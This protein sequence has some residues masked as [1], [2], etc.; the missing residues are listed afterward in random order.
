VPQA[1][2]PY[3]LPLGRLLEDLALCSDQLAGL[4]HE[5]VAA[6]PLASW[7]ETTIGV[8]YGPRV[9][10]ALALLRRAQAWLDLLDRE[11]G[12]GVWLPGFA[13]GAPP[14]EAQLGPR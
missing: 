8:S 9:R 4:L 3:T 1:G 12:A 14:I 2:A 7:P 10:S 6:L 5:T 13:P 11:T